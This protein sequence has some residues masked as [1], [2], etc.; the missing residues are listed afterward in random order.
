MPDWGS[1]V[2]CFGTK[3]LHINIYSKLILA[4]KSAQKHKKASFLHFQNLFFRHQ[5]ESTVQFA[6]F[7]LSIL[8]ANLNFSSREKPVFTP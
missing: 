1:Q 4:K 3:L 2:P 6:P 8:A 7:S 5:E